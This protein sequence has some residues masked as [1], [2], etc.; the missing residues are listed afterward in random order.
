MVLEAGGSNPL[1]HPK[2]WAGIDSDTGG[3]NSSLGIH[4]LV[5]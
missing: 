2:S 5:A 1:V 4:G 3:T